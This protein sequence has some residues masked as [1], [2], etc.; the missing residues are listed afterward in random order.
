M[1]H[2]DQNVRIGLEE[3]ENKGTFPY[4]LQRLQELAFDRQVRSIKRS[5]EPSPAA[6]SPKAHAMEQKALIGL[7][8]SR[9]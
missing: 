7:V 6:G 9:A 4:V 5:A 3:P 1:L 8:L 2:P